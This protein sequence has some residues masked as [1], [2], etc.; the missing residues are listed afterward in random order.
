MSIQDFGDL[1]LHSA[2]IESESSLVLGRTPIATLR[3]EAMLVQAQVSMSLA[4]VA[5]K[6][7]GVC[8]SL[9]AHASACRCRANLS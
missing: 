1:G 9:S 3:E 2:D 6:I 7:G 5:A 8:F 4:V